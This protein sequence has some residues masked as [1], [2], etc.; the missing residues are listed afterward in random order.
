MCGSTGDRT[1]KF[2]VRS[3]IFDALLRLESPLFT[4]G[5]IRPVFD[6]FPQ[7]A[8]LILSEADLAAGHHFEMGAAALHGADEQAAIRVTRQDVVTSAGATGEG[9]GLAGEVQ[10]WRWQ[11]A[12]VAGEA[13]LLEHRLHLR[14]EVTLLGVPRAGGDG[15]G[16]ED[17]K[18][19]K[20]ACHGNSVATGR[21]DGYAEFVHFAA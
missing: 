2:D 1:W 17:E 5:P 12:V 13:V 14:E 16:A 21:Q 4:L 20:K 9:S 8:D 3:G 18:H 11:G 15:A 6:P 7:H 10:R 19:G